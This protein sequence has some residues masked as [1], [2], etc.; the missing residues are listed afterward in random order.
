ML[1][2]ACWMSKLCQRFIG[3]TGVASD[4]VSTVVSAKSS[5]DSAVVVSVVELMIGLEVVDFLA[6]FVDFDVEFSGLRVVVGGLGKMAVELVEVVVFEVVKSVEATHRKPTKNTKEWAWTKRRMPVRRVRRRCLLAIRLGNQWNRSGLHKRKWVAE[7]IWELGAWGQ[8]D[9]FVESTFFIDPHRLLTLADE[10]GLE[11]GGVER[12]C[13]SSV[14]VGLAHN[15]T[16]T[17]REAQS[18]SWRDSTQ[19]RVLLK[20]VFVPNLRI[21]CLRHARTPALQNV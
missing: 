15:R 7:A 19:L 14:V 1:L 9:Q 6:F 21:F 5:T 8:L 17:L 11:S 20:Q 12:Y 10:C 16:T 18:K 13:L 4:A 2:L 3:S